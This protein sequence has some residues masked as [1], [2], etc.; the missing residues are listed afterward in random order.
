MSSM[1]GAA[2]VAKHSR[3]RTRN[4]QVACWIVIFHLAA[5][6]SREAWAGAGGCGPGAHCRVAIPSC[7]FITAGPARTARTM[8]RMRGSILTIIRVVTKA[9][10]SSAFQHR[11][12][13]G[14]SDRPP[15][16]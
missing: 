15:E 12:Q 9:W 14:R 2:R 8:E 6:V 5:L 4:F 7:R 13:A 1:T 3:A 11:I 16:D 10:L